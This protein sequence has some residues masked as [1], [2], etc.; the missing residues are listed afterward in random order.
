[1]FNS[2]FF[3]FPS[4][5]LSLRGRLL[6][7]HV[8]FTQEDDDH[9]RR[10]VAALG[11]VDWNAIADEMAGKNPRQCRER[12]INYLSPA[13]NTAAWT[14]AEDALLM[15]KYRD[16]GGKWVQISK[17]FPNRTDCM[18]KNRFNKLQRRGQKQ[19]SIVNKMQCSPLS[20]QAVV[21]WR[22]VAVP[23][24][25]LPTLMAQQPVPARVPMADTGAETE[26][27]VGFQGVD[28]LD[29]ECDIWGD[30]FLDGLEFW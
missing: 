28:T 17:C 9:L 30:P 22:P 19:Q 27:Q 21:Q 16:F 14:L 10:L 24:A 2:H 20:F 18:I 3:N 26:P 6:K 12:W 23:D 4:M 11:P 25:P 29:L 1:M 8:K 5:T 7:P 15:Q 13:L